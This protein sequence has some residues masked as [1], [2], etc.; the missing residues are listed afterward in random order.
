MPLSQKTAL[1]ESQIITDYKG[2]HRVAKKGGISKKNPESKY[3]SSIGIWKYQKTLI[4][5]G[6]ICIPKPEKYQ[7]FFF[8]TPL[9]HNFV[10]DIF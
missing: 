7:L 10:S 2:L 9:P 8:C 6:G 3:H 1:P 5:I 4:L